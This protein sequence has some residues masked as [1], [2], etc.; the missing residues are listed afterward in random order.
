MKSPES[1]LI[2]LDEYELDIFTESTF[3]KI[4]GENLNDWIV[5]LRTL[6]RNN[7]IVIIEKGK[8]CRHNFRDAYVIGN[9]LVNQGAVAY[10]SALNIHGLTEQITNSVF[11]QSP[12]FKRDKAVFAVPYRFIKIKKSKYTGIE[13]RGY[14]NNTFYI[15]DREKTMVDCFDLPQYA[16]EYPGI[17]RAFVN[18][19]WD[20]DKLIKYAK[21]VDNDAAIK[22]MGYFAELFK[23]P[24][25]E[26]IAFA[27]SRVTNAISLLDNS[28]PDS[29]IYSTGWGLRLNIE[30]A[31][32][33]NMKF[34]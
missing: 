6:I 23:L 21:A 26:F 15:T 5:Q 16:G 12:N 14:G 8:Y 24:L 10:W 17:I 29:G 1:L 20:E 28:S 27:K 4:S 9:Y 13:K 3:N 18:N 2:I 19:E 34:Y 30:T 22:R 31:D 7:L 33:L 11:I 32:L 25:Y